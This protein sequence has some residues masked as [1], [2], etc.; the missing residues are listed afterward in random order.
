MQFS[1]LFILVVER[2][3]DSKKAAAEQKKN[4]TINIEC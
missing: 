4:E 2:E 1:F 3:G